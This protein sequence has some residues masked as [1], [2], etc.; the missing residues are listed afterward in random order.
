MGLKVFQNGYTKDQADEAKRLVVWGE[1]VEKI[2]AKYLR[3]KI[4][5]EE[6]NNSIE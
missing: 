2:F 4:E 6:K 1:S 3:S 5:L